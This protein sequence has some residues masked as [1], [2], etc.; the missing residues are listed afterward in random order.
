MVKDTG[1][2]DGAS[3]IRPLNVPQPI[4]V[5]TDERGWPVAVCLG[6]RW[7]A[8]QV[9]ERWRIDDEWWRERGVVR[10]YYLVLVESARRT[11]VYNDLALGKWWR[12]E[13]Q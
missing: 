12:Q 2:A 8:A 4:E 10:V 1:K 9:V 7:L 11:T 13:Y 6:Q 3:R 5:K